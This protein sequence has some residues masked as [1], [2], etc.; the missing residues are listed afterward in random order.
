MKILIDVLHIVYWNFYKNAINLLEDRGIDVHLTVRPRGNLVKIIEFE[1]PQIDLTIIG[2]HQNY[3]RGK[4]IDSIT[5][6]YE[7]SNY[8][9]KNKIDAVSSDGFN[10]GFASKMARVP[11]LMHLD[12]FEYK[13]TFYLG[14]ISG[15]KILIP[16]SIPINGTNVIKYR[17]FKELAFLNPKYFKPSK[18]VLSEIGV[19]E[20]NYAYLRVVSPIS[21]NY[22]QNPI[23]IE[24]FK[25]II[26]YIKQFGYDVVLS[27]ESELLSRQLKKLCTVIEKPLK[28]HHSILKYAAFTISTGDSVARESCLVGTPTLYMGGRDMCV[29][30]ELIEMGAMFKEEEDLKILNFIKYNMENNLK[31]HIEKKINHSIK[32]KWENVTDVI[33]ENLIYLA[34]SGKAAK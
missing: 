7:L 14:M 9:R 4:V 13:T 29:N 26:N 33:V 6:T 32:Y 27:S 24:R 19:E 2:K 16:S 20:R 18:D 21:L 5:R 8:I 11:S 1:N 28:D 30:R 23:D 3:L 17:G 12:D 25:K 31:E 10:I 34:S 22:K 15:S